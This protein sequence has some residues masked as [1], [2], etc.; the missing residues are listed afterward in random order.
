MVGSW[1]V[2]FYWSSIVG[3]WMVG[4]YRSLMVDRSRFVV[5]RF[6]IDHYH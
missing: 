2:G 3:S 1:M 5:W 6:T 4:F